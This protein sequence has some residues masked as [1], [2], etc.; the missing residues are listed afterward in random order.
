VF[1][2]AKLSGEVFHDSKGIVPKS[3]YLD[4]LAGARS[5]NPVADFRIHPSQL[6][7]RLARVQ[8]PVLVNFDVVSRALDVPADDLLQRGIETL[9]HEI[10]I[11]RLSGKRV[12]RL[13]EPQSRVDGVIFRFLAR[14]RKSIGQHPAIASL[15]KCA[16]D[17]F[18]FFV[19]TGDQSKAR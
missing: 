13:E 19:V 6:N 17:L 3:L 7:T 12:D 18:S 5:D 14:V 8:E 10:V 16:Q 1:A 15:R 9:P 2:I 4:R 11:A